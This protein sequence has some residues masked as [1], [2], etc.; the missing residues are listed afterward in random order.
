MAR[1]RQA[2]TVASRFEAILG[3]TLDPDE[4]PGVVALREATGTRLYE[5]ERFVT[6]REIGTTGA[7][8]KACRKYSFNDVTGRSRTGSNGTVQ[9][10]LSDFYCPRPGPDPFTHPVNFVA[11][12]I[13]QLPRFVT[14]QAVL[15]TGDKDVQITVRAWDEAGRP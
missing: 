3:A 1:A 15:V 11:T 5:P 7:S 12:P 6:S 13:T 10:L 8:T 4:D 14:A 2:N 9:F